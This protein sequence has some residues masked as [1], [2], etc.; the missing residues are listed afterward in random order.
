[1]RYISTRGMAPRVDFEGALFS[2]YAPDGG[3]FMPEELPQLST[4]TLRQWS[5]LSYP[6]LVKELCTLF[7]GPELIPRDVLNGEHP[8]PPYSPT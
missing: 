1:M 8:Q 4:E 7:I 2:G 6:G 5:T 3:L